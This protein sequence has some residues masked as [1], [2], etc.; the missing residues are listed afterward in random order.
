[1]AADI[2]TLL[3]GNVQNLVDKHCARTRSTV[4]TNDVDMALRKLSVSTEY[5]G[6]LISHGYQSAQ[7]FSEYLEGQLIKVSAN[8]LD[9]KCEQITLL[10]HAIP[11]WAQY[12]STKF[13]HLP[14]C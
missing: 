13:E 8:G 2:D 6:H 12:P 4:D 7:N 1:M 3:L 5:P 9:T 14:C 11:V 10:R